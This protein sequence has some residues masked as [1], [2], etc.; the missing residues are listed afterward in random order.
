M[1]CFDIINPERVTNIVIMGM[2]EPL[3]NFD[4]VV[5]ALWNIVQLMGISRRRITV[6]TAGIVPKILLFSKK[7]PNVNLAI[8]LN[9]TNDVQ[10]TKLMPLNKKYPLKSLI[11]T[12]RKYPLKAGRKITF[13]YIMIEGENDSP[14]DA[15]RLSK[16]LHGICC[17]VNIIPLNTFPESGF[18][19]PA[20]E[21]ILKFQAILLDRTELEEFLDISMKG[22]LRK[23][24]SKLLKRKQSMWKILFHPIT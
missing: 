6:S 13:E 15:H 16:L 10:R 12:C 7:A 21:K 11:D 4:E 18:K 22:G 2:G 19:K 20:D 3:A 5:K 24:S 23:F 8:S 14:E 9:A 1:N 17:K